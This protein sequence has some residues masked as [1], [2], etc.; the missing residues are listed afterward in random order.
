MKFFKDGM[1][2]DGER[3]EWDWG[4]APFRMSDSPSR[5]VDLYRGS[6]LIAFKMVL[7]TEVVEFAI[8]AY[9]GLFW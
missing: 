2:L 1:Y 7:S 3:E 6:I 5:S 8:P 9:S 4:A